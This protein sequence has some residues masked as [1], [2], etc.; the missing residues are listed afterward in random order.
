[1]GLFD[2]FLGSNADFTDH[3]EA[4]RVRKALADLDERQGRYNACSRPGDGTFE[5]DTAA[6]E[7]KRAALEDQLD[8]ATC[9]GKYKR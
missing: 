3:A 7:R 8:W 6:M 2:R 9:S 4:A 1:M 5:R